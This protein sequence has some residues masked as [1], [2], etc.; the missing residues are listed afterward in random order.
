MYIVV[1]SF[2]DLQDEGYIYHAGDNYPRRGITANSDRVK[3]LKGANS[4]KIAYIKAAE[5][6]QTKTIAETPAETSFE[7]TSFEEPAKKP[8]KSEITLMRVA[9]LRNLAQENGLEDVDEYTGSELKEWLIKQ[10][11]L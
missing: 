10:L 11:G 3:F 7:E 5:Q 9:D 2:K 4:K 1:K 6:K 8:T